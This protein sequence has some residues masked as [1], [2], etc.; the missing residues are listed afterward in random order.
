MFKSSGA[1]SPDAT[2]NMKLSDFA[3]FTTP[4][5]GTPCEDFGKSMTTTKKK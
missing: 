5:T 2:T 3:K 1:Q 4:H